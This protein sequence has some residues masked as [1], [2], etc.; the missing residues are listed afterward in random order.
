M[1]HKLREDYK[2]IKCLLRHVKN[3]ADPS[4]KQKHLD[5]ISEMSTAPLLVIESPF[6]LHEDYS[7]P[8]VSWLSEPI[9]E[10][11]II[12]VYEN[13]SF[14]LPFP[15]MAIYMNPFYILI[16]E[17]SFGNFELFQI[18]YNDRLDTVDSS[19]YYG[20]V[21]MYKK[22]DGEYKFQTGYHE[23]NEGDHD[24]LHRVSS[25][26]FWALGAYFNYERYSDRQVMSVSPDLNKPLKG[27]RSNVLK[28]RLRAVAA[29]SSHVI[30]LNTMPVE[31]KISSGGIH[32]SPVGHPRRGYYYTL[33]H[34]RYS[35]HPLFQVPKA[36]YKKAV[37]VGPENSTF[38]G[39][40][41]K[42]CKTNMDGVVIP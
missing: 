16:Q 38:Q 3:V 24:K 40:T 1:Q 17:I 13:D 39:N 20:V 9:G 18:T 28:T 4:E 35:N 25:S 23:E 21:D 2:M 14:R 10:N 22:I 33:K 29:Q 36:L 34:E 8:K 11:R 42:M 27:L 5:S 7:P 19:A 31:K 32:A 37:W 26:I 12:K 6:S 15:M 41:Y 30:Y